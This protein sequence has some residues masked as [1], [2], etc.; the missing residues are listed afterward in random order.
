MK[1]FTVFRINLTLNEKLSPN[2][3]ISDYIDDFVHSKNRI[4]K[5]D[6]KAKRIRRALQRSK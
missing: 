2:S 3:S 5:G 1:S 4:F 6:S